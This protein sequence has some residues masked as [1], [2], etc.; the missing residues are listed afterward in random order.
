MPASMLQPTSM[1]AHA[2]LQLIGPDLVIGQGHGISL[3]WSKQNTPRHVAVWDVLQIQLNGLP[4]QCIVHK[5][6][7]RL[8]QPFVCVTGGDLDLTKRGWRTRWQ[9]A[10]MCTSTLSTAAKAVVA[11]LVPCNDTPL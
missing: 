4:A 7:R 5:Q 3:T 9:H 8:L 6:L 11:S 10:G 2:C 1:L